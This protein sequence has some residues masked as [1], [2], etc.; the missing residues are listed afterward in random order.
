MEEVAEVKLNWL[1]QIIQCPNIN[2][3]MVQNVT[4]SD[5]LT[6]HKNQKRNEKNST[7]ATPLSDTSQNSK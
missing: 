6:F 5:V 3:Q 1:A 7:L 4:R 2:F